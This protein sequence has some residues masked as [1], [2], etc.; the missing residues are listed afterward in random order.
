MLTLYFMLIASGYHVSFG[1][2]FAGYGLPFMLAKVPFIL[3]GGVGVVEGSMVAL[4]NSL[5]VPNVV[6]VVVILGYRLFSF[7][8]PNLLGFAAV[9]C[10]RY[11]ARKASLGPL[12]VGRVR[13][14]TYKQ[15]LISF[16]KD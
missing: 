5:K 8:L 12:R 7:W 2:L 15:N 16:D 6:S 9:G 3:P 14:H 10:N 1:I 13:E 11:K 4:Y